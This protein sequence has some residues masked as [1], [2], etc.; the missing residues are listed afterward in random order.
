VGHR[1]VLSDHGQT[2]GAR[3]RQR[4]GYNLH[5]LVARSIAGGSVAH[6][7]GGDEHDAEVSHAVA[8][9]TGRSPQSEDEAA[10]G[11]DDVIVLASAI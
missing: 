6:M 9:A 3:F 11:E 10:V 8:E 7:G 2:Q 5:N 4:N 1:G